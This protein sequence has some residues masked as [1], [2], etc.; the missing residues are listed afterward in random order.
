MQVLNK[1]EKEELAIKMHREGKT[2][3]EIAAT[4][5]MSF[6]NIGKIIR[7][8]D[9]STDDSNGS[10]DIDMSK[11]SKSTQALYLFERGKKPFDVAIQLDIPY[12][13]VE[14]LQQEFWALKNLYDLACMFMDI[15]NDLTP[16]VKLYK[17][18]ERNKMLD[19]KKILKF[20]K[21]A[22]DDLPAL[23]YRCN[24]LGS[25]AVDLQI[26]RKQL[27]NEVAALRSNIFQLE[28]L[29][30]RCQMDI[31]Q[32]KQIISN[33]DRQLNQKIYALEKPKYQSLKMAILSRDSSIMNIHG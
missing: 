10:N 22:N 19:E 24:K 26:T 7:K 29:Q 3:R 32:K 31:V 21:Y 2:L 20:I 17:L 12:S 4:A 13:E 5:H 27:G 14:D 9:G 28:T 11:K 30:R 33:L 15:K 16:F 8:I 25:D 23:E 1:F 6:S 18:L